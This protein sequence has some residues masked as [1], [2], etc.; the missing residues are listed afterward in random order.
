MYGLNVH[1]EV[2]NGSC[3]VSGATV[4]FVNKFYDDGKI[5]AQRCIDISNVKS[6]EEIASRVLEIEHRLLPYVIKKF[7]EGKIKI[8][9]NRVFIS[10]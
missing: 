2:Y 9:E 8:N 1:K 4:H 7:S 5:I 10:E 3:Q 6:P